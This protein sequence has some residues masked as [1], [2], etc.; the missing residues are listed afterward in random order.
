[1]AGHPLWTGQVFRGRV[2]CDKWRREGWGP[3]ELTIE[4]TGIRSTTEF[5]A[6]TNISDPDNKVRSRDVW[7]EADGMFD[8]RRREVRWL[9]TR[10]SCEC[11]AAAHLDGDA[12]PR[13]CLR[14]GSNTVRV[15]GY[16]RRN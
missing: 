10:W 14:A 8:P 9:C 12:A 5:V 1:M 4:V 6:L 13:W 16:S 3:V 15:A 7:M 11:A 2:D